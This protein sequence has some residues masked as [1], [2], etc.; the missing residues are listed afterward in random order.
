MTDQELL[1]LNRQGFIPGP[2]ESEEGFAERVLETRKIF[3]KGERLPLAHWDWVKVSLR[4]IF[5]FEPHYLPAFYSNRSL[6][7]WQGAATW[8][9]GKMI[10]SIQLREALKRGS[11][12]GLYKREEILAHEAVHAARS[13][14]DE[15]RNEE[16]FAYMTSE[17]KWHRTFG[18]MIQRP[19]EIWPFFCLIVGASF[20]PSLY[21]GAAVWLSIGFYRLIRQH[22]RINLAARRLSERI[23]ISQNHYDRVRAIL[24]RLTDHEIDLFSSGENVQIY[25]EKQNC[26]RWRLIRLAYLQFNRL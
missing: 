4:K 25:A 23:E 16:F 19:W 9:E 6:R 12:L 17:K 1:D 11:Y 10:V 26:L 24:F 8:I 7:I 13:A 21:W 14:F 20:F 5:D 18:P 22:R 3:E 15:S 2:S